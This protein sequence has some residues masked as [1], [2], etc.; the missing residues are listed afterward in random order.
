MVEITLVETK[1]IVEKNET[2]DELVVLNILNTLDDDIN[3]SDDITQTNQNY[4]IDSIEEEKKIIARVN[5][6]LIPSSKM[7][8]GFI[9][10]TNPKKKW[11]KSYKR[12]TSYNFDVGNNSWLMMTHKAKFSI[13]DVDN[14]KKYDIKSTTYFKID[15]KNGIKELSYSEYKSLGGYRVW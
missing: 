9:N 15:S 7:W 1:K 12:A 14:T 8:F 10:I 11:H 4:E 3:K 6:E 5:I 13:K 2:K